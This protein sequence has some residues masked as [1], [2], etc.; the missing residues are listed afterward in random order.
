MSLTM[1]IVFLIIGLIQ[2]MFILSLKTKEPLTEL[3]L[4]ESQSL[5][6]KTMYLSSDQLPE[7]CDHCNGDRCINYLGTGVDVCPV[8]WGSGLK[9][10]I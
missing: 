10:D 5:K 9:E 1:A 4:Q 6:L 7:K 3:L 2:L 8:C